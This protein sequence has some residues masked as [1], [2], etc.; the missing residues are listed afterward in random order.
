MGM[1]LSRAKFTT[2]PISTVLFSQ[3]N[4]NGINSKMCSSHVML[5][6]EPKL[7]KCSANGRCAIVALKILT[8]SAFVLNFLFIFLCCSQTMDYCWKWGK[9]FHIEWLMV[10]VLFEKALN[11]RRNNRG[12]CGLLLTGWSCGFNAGHLWTNSHNF[13]LYLQKN[14][15]SVVCIK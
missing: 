2:Q 13:I 9:P 14:N 3:F 15:I 11:Y 6:V 12:S 10:V 4:E 1:M 8:N 7:L 5:S